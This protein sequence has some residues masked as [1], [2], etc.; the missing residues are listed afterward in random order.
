MQLGDWSD[1]VDVQADL[2]LCWL[3][4]PYCRFW[5]ALTRMFLVLIWIASLVEA[6]QMSTNNICFCKESQKNIA[7]V[8]L[9]TTSHEVLCWS[10]SSLLIFP[11]ITKTR[12]YNFDPLKPHLYIV[13]LGFTGIYIIF[14]ILLKN[15]DCGNHLTKAVLMST[16]SLCLEKKYVKYQNFLSENFP[17]LVV[18]FSIYL[19]RHVFVMKAYPY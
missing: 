11:Y 18:K 2:S 16:Q 19:N 3:H 12:L 15:I 17:Y 6:I 13:K 8:S 7:Q 14:L 5:C 10:W 1:W 9:D 4:K